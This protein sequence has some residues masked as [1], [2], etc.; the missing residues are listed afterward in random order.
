MATDGW[1]QARAGAVRLWRR[2]RPEQAEAIAAELDEVRAEVVAARQSGDRG[3]E[4]GL[5]ADWQRKLQ[6]LVAAEPHIG[7]ELKQILDEEL[8][9]LLPPGEQERVSDIRQ[10]ITATAPGAV[11]QGVVHG[12]IIN[13][14]SA[15]RPAPTEGPPGDAESS[16]TDS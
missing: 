5:A 4:Q 2:A 1:Q 3:A 8:T 15:P 16:R 12:N 11:A 14:G 6:R 10:S 7:L 9:P 13:H